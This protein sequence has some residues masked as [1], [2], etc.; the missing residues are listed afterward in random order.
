MQAS[1]DSTPDT[2]PAPVVGNMFYSFRFGCYAGLASG[3]LGMLAFLAFMLIDP[4]YDPRASS[5]IP[6]ALVAISSC[7]GFV[8]GFRHSWR[9]GK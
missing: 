2:F 4:A 3:G 1:D 7:V 9:R 5:F 8:L 6:N